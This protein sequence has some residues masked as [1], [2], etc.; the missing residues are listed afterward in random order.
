MLVFVG[1]GVSFGLTSLSSLAKR[2]AIDS[3]Y[4]SCESEI[5]SPSLDV[6][7]VAPRKLVNPSSVNLNFCFRREAKN[8]FHAFGLF[9]DAAMS[10]TKAHKC[11]S[12]P[13]QFLL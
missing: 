5:D 6:V 2:I 7:I 1:N 10:S 9:V 8:F 3:K 12:P 13:W 4:G 11:I